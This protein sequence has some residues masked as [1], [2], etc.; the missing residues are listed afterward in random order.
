MDQ[1]TVRYLRIFVAALLFV[2]AAYHLFWGLPRSI[3]YGR[4]LGSYLARG[5]WPDPRPFFF[6]AYGLALLAGPYLVT[7]DVLSLRQAYAVGLVTMALAFLAWVFW[8]ET[9]HGAFLPGTPAPDTGGHD[10]GGG[11]LHTIADHYVVKPA[12]GVIKSVELAA[13]ALFAVLLRSDPAA[14]AGRERGTDE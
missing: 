5:V 10:H 11:V 1:R 12:E 8:H 3:I 14:R 4:V 2:T 7:R 6:V 13:A 9:G